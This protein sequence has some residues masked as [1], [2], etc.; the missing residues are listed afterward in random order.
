MRWDIRRDTKASIG[1]GVVNSAV[2]LIE[3]AHKILK[4]NYDAEYITTYLTGG[5][6]NILSDF[7]SINHQIENALVLIGVKEILKLNKQ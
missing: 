7:L 5:N 4:E 2:G 6:A 1:S 3:R